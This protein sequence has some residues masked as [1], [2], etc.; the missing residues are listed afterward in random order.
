[1]ALCD[2][3][4]PLLILLGYKNLPIGCARRQQIIMGALRNQPTIFHEEDMVSAADLREAVG[5]QQ[6]SAPLQDAAHGALDLVFGVAVDGAGRIVQHEDARVAEKG[7][8]NGNALALAAGE[9]DASFADHGFVAFGKAHNEV[10]R[11]RFFGGGFDLFLCDGFTRAKGDI[12]GNGAGEEEDV[13][14]NCADLGAQ[15]IH[16]PLAY[17]DAIDQHMAA[18]GVKGA[19][20]QFG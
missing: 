16:A 10:V 15:A 14:F 18:G 5:D 19:V 7:A 8:G 20:E 11:L 1:M 3:C 2:A 9:H 6:C 17:I 12:F 4:M 13:L